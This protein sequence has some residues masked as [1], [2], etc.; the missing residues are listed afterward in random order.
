[1]T[2]AGSQPAPLPGGGAGSHTVRR[3]IRI[4]RTPPLSRAKGTTTIGSV[5]V[6]SKR[7]GTGSQWSSGG[8]P[9]NGRTIWTHDSGASPSSG[10]TATSENAEQSVKPRVGRAARARR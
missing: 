4:A 1:M 9:L 7:G 5:G 3:Y 6:A 2:A 8:A 10:G